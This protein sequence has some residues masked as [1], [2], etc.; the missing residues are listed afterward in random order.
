MVMT[1]S[2]K[3]ICNVCRHEHRYLISNAQLAYNKT[4][5]E[6]TYAK[7]G[8]PYFCKCGSNKI[9]LKNV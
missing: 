3:L 1:D 8:E 6:M 4:T 2:I 5:G 7:S 9:Q